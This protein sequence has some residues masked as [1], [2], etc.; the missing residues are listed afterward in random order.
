MQMSAPVRLRIG[1]VVQNKPQ[2]QTS[3]PDIVDKELHE[4][5]FNINMM[6]DI[7]VLSAS[8]AVAK[9]ADLDGLFISGKQQTGDDGDIVSPAEANPVLN[10]LLRR[11]VARQ[12]P[13]L[14]TS[15]G[16]RQMNNALLAD[17][18]LT[19]TLPERGAS[20]FVKPASVENSDLNQNP[21]A[22]K[23]TAGHSNRVRFETYGVLGKMFPGNHY[24]Q[25]QIEHRQSLTELSPQLVPEAYTE[26]NQ[27]VA[28]SLA[29]KKSFY[30]AVN[31]KLH[32]NEQRIF[33]NQQL[34]KSFVL[35]CRK[36]AKRSDSK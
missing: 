9:I 5:A 35:A 34:I 30:L 2:G 16:F 28:Y 22:N 23:G 20:L 24:Q 1:Y 8:E 32:A 10:V 19:I 17:S 3:L 15:N 7:E 21:L 25:L 4:S 13:V 33:L 26:N 11:A 27:V 29:S 12:V 18:P 6:A 14:S 31:W 36:F